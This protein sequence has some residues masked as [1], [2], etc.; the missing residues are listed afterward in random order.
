MDAIIEKQ[1]HYSSNYHQ[2][3]SSPHDWKTLNE[4]WSV[5]GSEDPYIDKMIYEAVNGKNKY[6]GLTSDVLKAH[7]VEQSVEENTSIEAT[8]DLSMYPESF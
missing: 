3:F 4:F 5:G 1:Q 6:Y 2:G 8:E 7:G